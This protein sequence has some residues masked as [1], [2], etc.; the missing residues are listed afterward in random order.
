MFKLRG[1]QLAP[2][3][4]LAW[5]LAGVHYVDAAVFAQLV[6]NSYVQ[7]TTDT[8]DQQ[9]NDAQAIGQTPTGVTGLP[10]VTQYP[11]PSI[12]SPF[13]APYDTD[14]V[15][16][17]GVGGQIELQFPQPLTVASAGQTPVGVFT[18][19]ELIDSDYP[20]GVADNP[21]D[22]FSGGSAVVSV[23]SDGIHWVSLGNQT[24]QIPQNY[25]LNA[26]S[27]YQYPPPSD[28]LV[29]DYGKPFTGTLASFSGEDFAQII[30]TLDGS[31]GGTWLDL[32]ASGLSTISYIEFTE[33]ADLVAAG[34]V[35][36]L[37]AVSAANGASVPEPAAFGLAALSGLLALRRRTTKESK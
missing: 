30:A 16:T 9:F 6:P 10:G 15:V 29:A 14:Q 21:A 26:T 3:G 36:A 23:S 1:W 25:Y 12:V 19:F 31:A 33:P 8:Y 20:S 4:A 5:S 17:I 22:G 7:G 35:L 37:E 34:S 2:V 18:N 32:S 13:S 28:P 24:F 27:P 11:F